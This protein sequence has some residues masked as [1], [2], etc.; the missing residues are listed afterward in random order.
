MSFHGQQVIPVAKNKNQY[1]LFLESSFQYGV[2]LDMDIAQLKPVSQLAKQHNKNILLHA[3]MIQGLKNDEYSTEYLCQEIKP[4]GIIST[5]PNVILKA[6]QKG[7]LTVQ[8]IFL[9][10]SQA[11]QK[12]YSI[13]KHTKADY[14]EILPGIIPGFI[15]K[16]AEDHTIPI[17]TG[18]LVQT[19]DEVTCALNAGARAV[20]T[21]R[22]A[23][24]KSFESPVTSI[25][26]AEGG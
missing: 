1:N 26:K 17:L 3:D 15:R 20:T 23:L 8:R 7:V 9:L 24:W 12:S 22:V 16:M 25:T 14:V 18:G 13:L 10:D 21:S 5:K 4:F 19:R 11:L 2:Y 6:R